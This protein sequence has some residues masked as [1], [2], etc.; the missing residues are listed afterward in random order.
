MIPAIVTPSI[1][2]DSLEVLAKH[3]AAKHIPHLVV[4]DT[5]ELPDVAGRLP[6]ET[7]VYML[8]RP[9]SAY[10]GA[11]R[12]WAIKHLVDLGICDVICF[13]DDDDDFLDEGIDAIRAL[14][15]DTRLHVFPMLKNDQIIG[16]VHNE[17]PGAIG[18]SMVVVPAIPGL[19]LWTLDNCYY[20]DHTFF[21][22]CKR[23]L[24]EPVWH[25]ECLAQVT[26][27]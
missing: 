3:A 8:R 24:G 20:H 10:G 14:P 18:G 9:D 23:M 19:P 11:Q 25:R 27:A 21:I 16:I 7:M 13:I 15:K 17:E 4:F 2:R 6:D 26:T 22:N 12:D 5:D 1:G